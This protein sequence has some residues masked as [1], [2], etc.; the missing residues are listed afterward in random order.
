MKK[1]IENTNLDINLWLINWGLMR[2][3]YH[4]GIIKTT[5]FGVLNQLFASLLFSFELIKWIIL[6]YNPEDSQVTHYLGD[7]GP[8]IGPKVILDT[9]IILECIN[10]LILICYFS[11]KCTS[12]FWLKFMHFDFDNRFFD[13]LD[14]NE[15]DSEKFINQFALVNFL[16]KNINYLLSLI[17]FSL[18]LLTFFVLTN[19]YHFYYITSIIMFSIGVWYLTHHWFGLLM[20]FNQVIKLIKLDQFY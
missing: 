17:T 5:K 8:N 13:K 10:S 4:D 3:E 15:I 20:I 16:I 6:L 1:I 7:F 19:K 14:L 2:G 9:T 11:S 12:K 18:I